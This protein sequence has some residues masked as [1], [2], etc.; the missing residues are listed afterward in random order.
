MQNVE[1]GGVRSYWWNTVYFQPAVLVGNG[2][3]ET[4]VECDKADDD[5]RVSTHSQQSNAADTPIDRVL[6]TVSD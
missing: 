2:H 3:L 5:S 1:E 6:E 4:V